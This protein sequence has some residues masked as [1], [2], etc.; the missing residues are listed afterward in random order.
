MK[1][2]FCLGL[3]RTA[4]HLICSIN[5]VSTIAVTNQT[6]FRSS[7]YIFHFHSVADA[8]TW[9]QASAVCYSSGGALASVADSEE[10]TFLADAYPEDNWNMWLG[11]KYDTSWKWD[12]G[13]TSNFFAWQNRGAVSNENGY[14][15]MMY[16]MPRVPSRHSYWASQSCSTLSQTDPTGF[17]CKSDI[18]FC[19]LDA[20]TSYQMTGGLGVYSTIDIVLSVPEN[21]TC[22]IVL[23]EAKHSPPILL[24]NLIST[25]MQITGN[26]S[27]WF[28]GL[29]ED[30][31]VTVQNYYTEF[32]WGIIIF[33]SGVTS[34]INYQEHLTIP[35]NQESYFK[36]VNFLEISGGKVT[37][38]SLGYLGS[39]DMHFP[40][41]PD[42]YLR[43][44]RAIHTYLTSFTIAV[45]IKSTNPNSMMCVCSYSLKSR[46]AELALFTLSPTGLSVQLKGTVILNGTTGVLLDNKWHHIA[47]SVTNN[48]SGSQY[49]VFLDGLPWSPDYVNIAQFEKVGISIGGSLVVGQL[50]LTEGGGFQANASFTGDISEL[51]IWDHILSPIDIKLV[52]S[53]KVQPKYPGNV[54]SWMSLRDGKSRAVQMFSP[55]AKSDAPFMWFG[56]LY[57]IGSSTYL[58]INGSTQKL[59]MESALEK[60][61]NNSFWA[62]QQNGRLRNIMIPASC[63]KVEAS[64][65]LQVTTDCT[66]DLSSSFRLLRDGRLQNVNSGSCL[67]YSRY[68]MSAELQKC[69][70]SSLYMTL[71]ENIYCPKADG[72]RQWKNKCVYIDPQRSLNWKDARK[73]CQNF[74]S[75]D[76]ITLNDMDKVNWIKSYIKRNS[77]IGLND[78]ES[79]GNRVWTNGAPLFPT[80]HRLMVFGSSGDRSRFDCVSMQPGGFWADADCNQQMGLVC[81]SP[82]MN[83]AFIIMKGKYFYGTLTTEDTYSD[84]KIAQQYCAALGMGCFAVVTM[85]DVHYLYFGY[86]FANL[87][88]PAIDISAVTYVKSRCHPGYSGSACQSLCPVCEYGLECNP[89]TNL[90]D[91]KIF[92]RKDPDGVFY[93]IQ[94]PPFHGW[95]FLSN[96]CVQI[97]SKTSRQEAD[98]LCKRFLFA[99]AKERWTQDASCIT[100]VTKRGGDSGKECPTVPRWNCERPMD[101]AFAVFTEKILISITGAA[102]WSK[103]SLVEAQDA[104]Y[105]MTT[106]CTGIVDWNGNYYAV[107]GTVIVDSPGSAATLYVKTACAPGFFGKNCEELCPPCHRPQMCNPIIG[108]CD[109]FL[110]CVRRY[111]LSCEHGLIS[112]KCP[113]GSGWWFWRGHCYY[114]QTTDTKTW[115]EANMACR[116]FKGTTFLVIDSSEEKMWISAM[117]SGKSWTGLND[118]DNDG[119]WTWAENDPAD[120]SVPWLSDV[121]SSP[122]GC[123][124]LDTTG[125]LV[126][127]VDCTAKRPWICERDEAVDLFQEIPGHALL[128][129]FIYNSSTLYTLAESKSA[130]I[131]ERENCTGVTQWNNTF[132]L[133]TGTQ[134]MAAEAVPVTAYLKTACLPGFFGTECSYHCHEC[135]GDAACN[136]LTGV[137][138]NVVTCVTGLQLAGCQKA[139]SLECPQEPGWWFW[140]G[141]CYYISEGGEANTWDD[142]KFACSSYQ[143]TWLLTINSLQEKEWVSSMI[144]GNIWTGLSTTTRGLIWTWVDR[145]RTNMSAPWM[146]VTPTSFIVNNICVNLSPSPAAL[147]SDVCSA[148]H[149][150]VCEQP[151]ISMFE[152]HQGMILLDPMP[153]SQTGHDLLDA[154]VASCI[155]HIPQCTGV[156]LRQ[157]LHYPVMGT[158]LIKSTRQADIAYLKSACSVGF[159]GRRCA[160]R[161]PIC[162]KGLFCNSVLGECQGGETCVSILGH[163]KSCNY[164][165][166]SIMCPNDLWRVWNGHCYYIETTARTSGKTSATFCER[167]R[168]T[169]LIS[170]DN[171]DEKNFIET[172]IQHA[173]HVPVTRNTTYWIQGSELPNALMCPVLDA[174]GEQ[175][176]M[177]CDSISYFICEGIKGVLSRCPADPRWHYWKGSCYLMDPQMSVTWIEAELICN[178]YKATKLLYMTSLREKEAISEIFKGSF[179]TGLNDRNL[180]SV[181]VWTTGEPINAEV[182]L[183][184]NDDMADG[185]LKDCVRMN[186]TSKILTDANC[187]EKKPFIC[188]CSEDTEWFDTFLGQGFPGDLSSL[189]PVEKSLSSAK[190]SCQLH[191]TMCYGIIQNGTNFYL[192]TSSS[193]LVYTDGTTA[194]VHNICSVGVKGKLCIVPAKPLEELE[195]D[196]SGTISTPIGTVCNVLPVADCV[197][198]CLQ[199]GLA[200]DC[201]NCVPICPAGGVGVLNEEE[202]SFLS[203]MEHIAPQIQTLS[204]DEEEEPHNLTQNILCSVTQP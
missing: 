40:I 185:G 2:Q 187:S 106:K 15:A 136:P 110:R 54:V 38:A 78:I 47:L 23:K 5:F 139:K 146:S 104:C 31:L 10:N 134:L 114:I 4:L 62:L 192:V 67:I 137:C 108:A 96:T 113:Q 182:S 160:Q 103:K 201:S 174:G 73:F 130:C 41:G 45:W 50:E 59:Y 89:T 92:Y 37:G 147:A 154:A 88:D 197:S 191:R 121:K 172:A 131:L 178:S 119:K 135:P 120:I 49:S 87:E 141:H 21:S 150:W 1:T 9:P 144:E 83:E 117:I 138:D 167:F 165:L 66:D 57:S 176:F 26:A 186:T 61:I 132:V 72:W 157:G 196:C 179:W 152:Q 181:F 190:E 155:A 115:L 24:L 79:E 112:L 162:V 86:H 128:I 52:A 74:G 153:K 194:Y 202:I 193:P 6:I 60:C 32:V 33:P 164:A 46:P 171:I 55:G 149:G 90:C 65:T 166:T 124:E 56:L 142:A 126:S 16:L 159:F 127:Q 34:Y 180:E 148:P 151:V 71:I 170:I 158:I 17:I 161:C 122:S 35:G 30:N 28:G 116:R 64:N 175:S 70:S 94:C 63:I 188:K 204:T 125:S 27:S 111:S 53:T 69:S 198:L 173:T 184:L 11:L 13:S 183:F 84:L 140:D 95:S 203:L 163:L 43:L 68:F 39:F 3:L 51:N 93:H 44:E 20:T 25:A 145:Q 8:K 76:L 18:K 91:G 199:Q 105:M 81:E 107:N 99:E 177:P 22:K 118:I 195:C 156:T 200:D 80:L 123:I 7:C 82:A 129:P 100:D 85:H 19:N 29:Q 36:S 14:C 97:E 98:E 143:R 101:S 109:S 12:D 189:F 42:N 58:C 102:L 75:S 169:N 133:V 77:W 48:P 168:E